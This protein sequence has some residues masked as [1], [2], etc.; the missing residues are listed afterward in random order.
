MDFFS[1]YNL[2]NFGSDSL[3]SIM[4]LSLRKFLPVGLKLHFVLYLIDKPKISLITIITRPT[5]SFCVVNLLY[6]YVIS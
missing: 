6:I 4:S 3:Y 1:Y 5:L 2:K